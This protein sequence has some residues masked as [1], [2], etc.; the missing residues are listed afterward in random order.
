MVYPTMCG[1]CLLQVRATLAFDHPLR[2][3]VVHLSI[4]S[5]A[6]PD[7]PSLHPLS[8]AMSDDE[9]DRLT[10]M[11]PSTAQAGARPDFAEPFA[12]L[13]QPDGAERF[14]APS[15]MA[16]RLLPLTLDESSVCTPAA[17]ERDQREA[18]QETPPQMLQVKRRI[19]G[20]RADTAG[21]YKGNQLCWPRDTWTLQDQELFLSQSYRGQYLALMYRLR[22]WVA[23]VQ[24]GEAPEGA[25]HIV[26]KCRDSS[27]QLLSGAAKAELMRGFLEGT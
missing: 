6:C 26:S 9:L 19:G 13:S 15:P 21:D 27:F 14:A 8:P 4:V 23:T 7:A 5:A 20:R 10:D 18:L 16:A 12:A 3:L 2:A 11:E 22:R 1:A 25:L 24:P 17:K